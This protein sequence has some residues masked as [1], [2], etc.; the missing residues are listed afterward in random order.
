MLSAACSRRLRLPCRRAPPSAAADEPVALRQSV[1]KR[2]QIVVLA[3]SICSILLGLLPL[4]SLGILLIGRNQARR[5]RL[6]GAPPRRSSRPGACGGLSHDS[7]SC[8]E[9]HSVPPC[10]SPVSGAAARADARLSCPCTQYRRSP[11]RFSPQAVSRSA[12]DLPQ[13]Q[14]TLALDRPAR[15]SSRCGIALDGF[16]RLRVYLDAEHAE[17]RRF[18]VSGCSRSQ[19]AS[20]SSSRRISGAS[21]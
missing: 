11:P 4:G 9:R 18:S 8:R 14:I 6:D 13:L 16:R 7:S 17:L 1:P 15:S 20:A 21:F 3:L 19:A 12:L 2:R 5:R 10:S